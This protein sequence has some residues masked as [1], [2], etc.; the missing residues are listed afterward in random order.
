MEARS[1]DG[2]GVGVPCGGLGLC[3]TDTVSGGQCRRH[4][5]RVPASAVGQGPGWSASSAQPSRSRRSNGTSSWRM[6]GSL[7]GDQHQPVQDVAVE[8]V[9]HR[10]DLAAELVV[11]AGLQ[12]AQD[13]V[14]LGDALETGIEPA[15]RRCARASSRWRMA[16]SYSSTI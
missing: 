9:Q 11:E 6:A 7:Q 12:R 4:A 10:C 8:A 3:P 5:A 2:D 16:R 13:R 14:R 1:G 15:A